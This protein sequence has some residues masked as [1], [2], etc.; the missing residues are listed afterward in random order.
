MP[1]EAVALH[2]R[3]VARR[4]VVDRQVQRN[5]AVATVHRLVGESR[6]R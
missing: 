1:R 2:R 6:G 3:R 5:N 4:A